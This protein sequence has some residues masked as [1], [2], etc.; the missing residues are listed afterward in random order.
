MLSELAAKKGIASNTTNLGTAAYTAYDVEHVIREEGYKGEYMYKYF[1]MGGTP[2]DMSEPLAYYHDYFEQYLPSADLVSIQLGGNDLWQGPLLPLMQSENPIVQIF[3]NSISQIL[4]GS[5]I[6][7]VRQYAEMMLEW[8]QDYI[9]E[10][11]V[12]EAISAMLELALSGHDII[13]TAATNMENV[14]I[15]VKEKNPNADIAILGFYNPYKDPVS[16]EEL[17]STFR[18]LFTELFDALQEY[19]SGAEEKSALDA[20]K[21]KI[22]S[23]LVLVFA[24]DA[25]D[26][27]IRVYNLRAKQV[28]RRQGATYVDIMN[29]ETGDDAEPHPPVAGHQDI[30][31]RMWNALSKTVSKKMTQ[32]A[33]AAAAATVTEPEVAPEPEATPEDTPEPEAVPATETVTAPSTTVANNTLLGR[34]SNTVS[35]RVK[36]VSTAVSV[37]RGATASYLSN[38]LSFGSKR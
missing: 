36:A 12:T 38:A 21:Q 34:V 15:A 5:S 32:V 11:Q 31:Y 33:T 4:A 25:I 18:T 3:A 19:W 20:L 14:V 7:M 9:T 22:V 30:A 35:K 37:I 1:L 2:W 10:E 29:I 17:R 8:Y 26:P 27:L 16:I 28:A 23:H 6:Q 13:E 24:G